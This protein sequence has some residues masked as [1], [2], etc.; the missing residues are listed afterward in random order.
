MT[1]LGTGLWLGLR[2][3]NLSYLPGALRS[4]HSIFSPLL[5][6]VVISLT[7]PPCVHILTRYSLLLQRHVC[8]KGEENW[9][10]QLRIEELCL[11][12]WGIWSVSNNHVILACNIHGFEFNRA[13]MS[14]LYGGERINFFFLIFLLCTW[15]FNFKRPL[16]FSVT[17]CLPLCH[18]PF[19]RSHSSTAETLSAD[20]NDINTLSSWQTIFWRRHFH[21][22]FRL[23]SPVHLVILSREEFSWKRQKTTLAPLL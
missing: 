3:S 18:T 14:F 23:D 16:S 2:G 17:S 19:P 6:L 9:F 4:K 11:L 8:L 5:P 10:C 22:P 13:Q 20:P 1:P 15:D 12:K 21:Q 7:L